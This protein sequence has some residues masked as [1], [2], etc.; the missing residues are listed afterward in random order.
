MQTHVYPFVLASA[1]AALNGGQRIDP[2]Q[3]EMVY[4]YAASPE[5]PERFPYS[6]TM[7]EED[8]QLLSGTI[9][10][11][12]ALATVDDF[13][14]T[15]DES[16]CRFCVYR[17]LDDRGVRAGDLADFVD[18]VDEAEDLTVDFEQIAEIEF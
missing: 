3:I 8:R 16:K 5:T 17:S 4:W 7:Y 14:L 13:P 1:G 12:A 9:G 15:D 6:Q 18:P 2:A 11:I 10:E